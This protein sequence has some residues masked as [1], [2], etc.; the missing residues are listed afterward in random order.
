[1]ACRGKCEIQITK[2]VDPQ[3]TV[4]IDTD[5][6][7]GALKPWATN[8]DS[9]KADQAVR[10][11]IAAWLGT[12]RVATTDCANPTKCE[13]HQTDNDPSDDDWK[14]KKTLKRKFAKKFKSNGRDFEAHVDLEYQ[15]AYVAGACEEP[16]GE[17]FYA[18]SVEVPGTGITLFAD[19]G[20]EITD[21]MVQKIKNVLG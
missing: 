17:V 13:C 7:G 6:T 14:T 1:M 20:R 19:D 8:D 10:Q 15:I 21:A 2:L 4:G 16:S 18:M 3:F 5:P 12:G 9:A 11:K